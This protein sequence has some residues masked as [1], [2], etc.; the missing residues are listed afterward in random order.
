MLSAYISG[1]ARGY[2][3]PTPPRHPRPPPSLVPPDHCA[4]AWA[5]AAPQVGGRQDHLDARGQLGGRDAAQ[6]RGGCMPFRDPS[7][8][9]FTDRGYPGQQTAL[10]LTANP[11]ANSLEHGTKRVLCSR[12][13]LVTRAFSLG[14]LFSGIV[15]DWSVFKLAPRA[16]GWQ[17]HRAIRFIGNK[18]RNGVYAS[19]SVETVCTQANARG[20]TPFFP[21]QVRD[22]LVDQDSDGLNLLMHAA[23]CQTAITAASLV[24]IEGIVRWHRSMAWRRLGECR[25]VE[26]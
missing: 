15:D 9:G 14:L 2:Q 3:T 10:A 8:Q 25:G 16:V 1:D 26:Q 5:T 24:P 18:H 6:N 23:S 4:G 12:E 13:V 20:R 21:F 7:A 19:T 17:M 11:D 22:M